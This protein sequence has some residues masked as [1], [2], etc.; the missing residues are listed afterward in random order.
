MQNGHHEQ[1]N[2]TKKP[3]KSRKPTRVVK[4]IRSQYR[5]HPYINRL[6]ENLQRK[7][8]GQIITTGF[9][10]NIKTTNN[11]RENNS[12]VNN[13]L[14]HDVDV[15]HSDIEVGLNSAPE[16]LN[17]DVNKGKNT[18]KLPKQRNN[19]NSELNKE[20][21]IEMPD[22]NDHDNTQERVSKLKNLDKTEIGKL[23]P[24]E[25]IQKKLPINTN[26]KPSLTIKK[27]K[28]TNIIVCF[29][30]V[31]TL[32]M[33]FVP[34]LMIYLGFNKSVDSNRYFYA[35]NIIYLVVILVLIF[36][37]IRM[38]GELIKEYV[39]SICLFC[40]GIIYL[41]ICLLLHFKVGMKNKTS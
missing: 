29:N 18:F 30:I 20:E 36:A 10:D 14:I 39:A 27:S 11:P 32:I 33:V 4:R 24:E 31:L 15:F 17:V 6:E 23:R 21:I 19:G 28:K 35:F 9:Y 8:N 3:L 34:G 25:E 41:S 16:Q 26:N 40:V 12:I 22:I 38:F 13:S 37:S 1:Q 7:H 2:I 5:R